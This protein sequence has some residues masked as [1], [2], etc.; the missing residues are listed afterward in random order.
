MK[1]SEDNPNNTILK[2]KDKLAIAQ[3]TGAGIKKPLAILFRILKNIS[4]T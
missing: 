3:K 2:R 1:R 4:V